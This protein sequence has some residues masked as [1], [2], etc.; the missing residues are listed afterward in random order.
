MPLL[1]IITI[2]F[3]N[4]EGLEK[5]IQSVR[6]QTFRDVE[7][8]VVD[9]GSSDGSK[10][11]L[12]KYSDSISKWISEKDSGIYNAMN[13][14]I[15]LANGKYL[16][17]L[18]SGD[19]LSHKNVLEEF[20]QNPLSADIVSGNVLMVGSTSTLA[21]NP[22]TVD[23]VHLFESTILHPCT[24]IKKELFIR[25]GMYDESYRIVADYEFFVRAF[26]KHNAGYEHRPII[27]AHFDTNGV[28]N[29]QIEKLKAERK[30]VL[31]NY[32]SPVQ[33]AALREL[34]EIKNNPEYQLLKWMNKFFFFRVPIGLMAKLYLKFRNR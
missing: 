10:E 29:Q 11:L 15:A 4:R 13:K 17:F 32:F 20:F 9:G 23:A 6:T 21:K 18:N 14:G 3:N 12:E 16:Q 19:T 5:T 2:N 8:I 28:S 25:Y 7:Y 27:V 33:L 26:V 30:R 31:E 22:E 24:F 1:S 34:F